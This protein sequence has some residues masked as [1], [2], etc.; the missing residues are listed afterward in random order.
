MSE[1][2]TKTSIGLGGASLL[3]IMTVLA[4]TTFAVLS[5][6]TAQAQESMALR[7]SEFIARYYSAD[8]AGE[9]LRAE[10]AEALAARQDLLQDT[11]AL[12]SYLDDAYPGGTI[13][14]YAEDGAQYL[15]CSLPFSDTQQFYLLFEID[16]Q[17]QRL[18][19]ERWQLLLA[20]D[21]ESYDLPGQVWQGK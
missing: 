16:P 20:D 12:Q 17:T 18:R 2:R 5:L 6:T 1:Q 9:L 3:M 8:Q 13:V 19:T 14:A 15:E 21:D 4:L 7:G 10:I 11:S